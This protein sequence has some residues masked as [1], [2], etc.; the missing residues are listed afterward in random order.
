M[1]MNTIEVIDRGMKCLSEHLGP[2]ETERFMTAILRERFDY[3]E[4]RHTMVDQINTFDEL[5]SFVKAA[6]EEGKFS[7][8]AQM[9]L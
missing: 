8:N 7:G 9:V 4:W 1:K 2:E 3:T 5:D 6:G